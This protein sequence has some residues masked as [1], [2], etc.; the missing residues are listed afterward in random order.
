MKALGHVVSEKKI[1]F[2]VFPIVSLWELL[3]PWGV[4]IFDHRGMI[5]SIY[6]KLLITMLH[7]K[8]RSLGS[9][10]FREEDFTCISHYKTMADDDAPR[11]GPVWIPGAQLAGF[12][13]RTTIHCYTQNMEALGLV[14]SEK[15]FFY[16][17]PIV[18]LWELMT[19]WAGQFLTPG[20]WLAGFIKRTTI[21]CYIQ[22]MKALGL[23][24]SQKKIFYVFSMP[25]PGLGLY[26]PQGHGW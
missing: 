24:V 9:C 4:A 14:I 5:R 23:V 6:V 17:F 20:A 21:H 26:G 25:S 18:N 1:F 2:H 10:S 15:I 13:K 7:T 11:A 22:N 16:V 12:I 3:T 8:Y 19:P